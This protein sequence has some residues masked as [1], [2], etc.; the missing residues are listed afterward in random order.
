VNA[1]LLG[2]GGSGKVYALD[3]LI[4]HHGE[5][6]YNKYKRV[7]VKEVSIVGLTIL[8]SSLRRKNIHKN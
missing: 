6:K 5:N 2:S 8:N 4:Q 1:K 7:A 3:L